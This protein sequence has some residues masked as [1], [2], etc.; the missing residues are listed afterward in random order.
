[1]QRC[2]RSS[3]C[4]HRS[5]TK[6]RILARYESAWETCRLEPADRE[7]GGSTRCDRAPHLTARS[8]RRT[9]LSYCAFRI[10]SG[11][12]SR[13]LGRKAERDQSGVARASICVRRTFLWCGAHVHACADMRSVEPRTRKWR[14]KIVPRNPCKP[15]YPK[16]IRTTFNT[17]AALG[18]RRPEKRSGHVLVTGL[19]EKRVANPQLGYPLCRPAFPGNH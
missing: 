1:M 10:R 14:L 6:R 17:P 15:L 4:G 13:Y 8:G 5:P 11:A 3:S 18:N 9:D 7:S 19:I 2:A 12:P 16:P